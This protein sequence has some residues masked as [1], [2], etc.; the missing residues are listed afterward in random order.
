MHIPE[1]NKTITNVLLT[2]IL[3]TI[4]INMPISI[5]LPAF[6][7]LEICLKLFPG[8]CGMFKISAEKFILTFIDSNDDQ[9][10]SQTGECLHL[11]Q[12]VNI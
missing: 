7:C 10:I 12:Q 8:S 1:L 2:K 3:E 5:I 9:L 4:N 6:K 11:L